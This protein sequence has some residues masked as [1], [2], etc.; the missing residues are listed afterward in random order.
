MKIARH[1]IFFGMWETSLPTTGQEYGLAVVSQILYCSSAWMHFNDKLLTENSF[2]KL[3]SSTHHLCVGRVHSLVLLEQLLAEEGGAAL[4][5]GI[6]APGA[7]GRRGV[8]AVR[9]RVVAC[10]HVLLER[11]EAGVALLALRALDEEVLGTRLRDWN[12]TERA[13]GQAFRANRS[14]RYTSCGTKT[15]AVAHR[16]LETYCPKIF[17]NSPKLPPIAAGPHP[18]M[19]GSNLM[20]CSHRVVDLKSAQ[21]TANSL[22]PIKRNRIYLTRVVP[23]VFELISL[24]TLRTSPLPS[25]MEPRWCSG[26]TTCLPPRRTGFN[27]RLGR[28]LIFACGNR[29]GR[30]F[31]GDLPL[32]PPLHSGAA[33]HLPHFT[34]IGS[35]DLD[36]QSHPSISPPTSSVTSRVPR[37]CSMTRPCA[38]LSVIS[39]PVTLEDAQTT[40]RASPRPQ[41]PP[42]W[43]LAPAD[44]LAHG[45]A[46]A[47][48]LARS[49]PTKAN[50]AS[51][52]GR[53]TGLSQV[54]IALDDTVGRR[55]FSRISRFP[56]PFIP[57][58][59][60]THFNHPRRLSRHRY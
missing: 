18:R 30:V 9:R 11:L 1:R 25:V 37:G 4:G 20:S 27:S 28:S 34:F 7:R 44:K 40:E 54:E 32:P 43:T 12:N 2:N 19:R 29:T 38:A 46:A 41:E 51:I 42:R 56:R 33:P 53:V 17:A 21:F 52:P 23:I 16:G 45:A 6:A 49:P 15:T 8:G 13:A 10:L 47:E 57:A 24:Q 5:A 35:Q 3:L 50:R 60:H 39:S 22:Y 55:V 48:R 59:L 58:P 31:L 26:Q 14:G 36:D